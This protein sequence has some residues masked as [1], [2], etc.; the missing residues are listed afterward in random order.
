M[1]WT[2]NAN[3]EPVYVASVYGKND[4]PTW[5]EAIRWMLMMEDNGWN[6]YC[7]H[8]LKNDMPYWNIPTELYLCAT[9]CN[10]LNKMVHEDGLMADEEF[11]TGLNNFCHYEDEF[12]RKIIPDDEVVVNLGFQIYTGDVEP[13]YPLGKLIFTVN[14]NTDPLIRKDST[15]QRVDIRGLTVPFGITAVLN[16]TNGKRYV[17]DKRDTGTLVGMVFKP[18]IQYFDGKPGWKDIES[19]NEPAIACP[20]GYDPAL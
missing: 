16:G 9:C 5:D 8:E 19:N 20:A 10:Q 1:P 4:L 2:K 6:Y 14:N 12:N 13:D 3:N 11:L 7:P 18:I 15:Y 17:A